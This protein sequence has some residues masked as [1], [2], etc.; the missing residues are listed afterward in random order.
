MKSRRKGTGTVYKPKGSRFWWIAYMSG[1]KRRFEGTKSERR[2]DAQAMLVQRLG[3]SGKGIVITPQMGKTT[4]LE[5][6][7]AFI[8]DLKINKKKSAHCNICKQ[9]CDVEGHTNDTWRRIELHVLTYFDPTRRMATITMD[10]I[11]A[12]KVHRAVTQGAAAASVN[13][14]LAS[15]RR[16][17]RL[18]M[19]RN[20]IASMPKI[21][22]LEENNA[23]SGFFEKA[24]FDAVLSHLPADLQPVA[25]FFYTTGWRKS[26]VLSLTVSQV[27]LDAGTVKLEVG[28]TKSGY[29]RTFMLTEELS[30]LLSLQL[31]SINALKKAGTICP[32]IFHRADGTQIKSMRGAWEAATEAAGYPDKLIHDFR[33]TA[34]R[35]LERAAVPRSTAMA[36]VGHETESIYNRYAIQD[37]AML[38]EG[39]AK[40]SAW[41]KSQAAAAAV[42]QRGQV[43]QF[44]KTASVKG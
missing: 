1:G 41:S 35:N 23:R 6:L 34:V 4:L 19:N 44:K 7:T 10:D 20:A 22:M 24:E 40:L 28:K 17:F 13:R 36:M 32:W 9:V 26:E 12:Y 8:N 33:R 5:G 25:K 3:D 37:E 29:G 14:E 16:A 15:L 39:S 38:R 11:E 43:K 42:K 2:C 30:E 18:A 31:D 21:K 27:D